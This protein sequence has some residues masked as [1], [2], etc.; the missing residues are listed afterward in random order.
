V[1]TTCVRFCANDG[2]HDVIRFARPVGDLSNSLRCRAARSTFGDLMSAS[3]G[4]GS[5]AVGFGPF[6]LF[7]AERLLERDGVPV[8]LG[9]RAIDILI[10]LVCRAGEVVSR[11][12]LLTTVWP[13]TV[14]VESC[15]RVQVASLRKALGDGV[16]GARFVT[17]VAGRGYCFVAPVAQQAGARS[18]ASLPPVPKEPVAWQLAH[19]LP[20]RLKRMAGRDD[21][22]DIVIAQLREHRFVTIVGAGGIGKTTVAVSVGHALLSD[23]S[24]AVRFVDLQS[25]ADPDLVAPTVASA[26]GLIVQTDVAVASLEA[27]LRDRRVL[28]VLDNC[29]HIVHAAAP[30]TERL[31]SQAPG[32]H[33]LTT[34]REALRVEGERVHRL[35]P[36]DAPTSY[37][38]LNASAV[39]AFP[40]VQVFMERA[41]ASGGS[42]ELTDDDAP[43][44]AA[45]CKR[46][47]GVALAIEVAAGFVGQFGVRGTAGLLDNRFRLLRQQGRR[48]APPRQRTLNALIDW[49]YDRLPEYERLVLRRLSVFF[50]PFT[51]EAARDVATDSESET[52]QF[53]DAVAELVAKSLVSGIADGSTILYRLLETTRAYATERIVESGERDGIAK[54]HALY[55]AALLEGC[56]PTLQERSITERASYLSNIRAG[57]Q[58]SF[59]SQA[60]LMTGVRLAAA[61]APLLLDLT[62]LSEC[63]YSTE[64][65]L[66]V[67]DASSR[68]DSR[69]MVLQ[70][71]FAISTM[72][73]RGNSDNVRA[74]IMRGL[75]L[76]DALGE[77]SHELRLLA[78]LNIF[79]TRIGDFLGALGAAERAL[80]VAQQ[81]AKPLGM[82]MAEW[83]L[84]V[85]HH[86]AGNQGLAL[87][88]C[89]RGM[90][91]AGASGPVKTGFFGY[92]HRVRALVAL[93]R[94]L[95]LRG[96]SEQAVV[97]ARRAI[98]AAAQ[99]DQPID[100]CISFI[101]TA[102]VFLWR[103]DWADARDVIERLIAHAERHSLAPYHAVGQALKGE[104]CVK[105]GDAKSGC[106]MLLDAS[107]RLRAE[108]HTILSTVIAAALA[109][110]R[111][112]TGQVDGALATIEEAIAEG[113]RRGEPFDM[114]ELLR[115]KGYLLA[116]SSRRDQR[117]AEVYLSRSLACARRQGALAWEL[118]TATTRAGFGLEMPEARNELAA[119]YARFTEGLETIDLRAARKL[120]EQKVSRASAGARECRPVT[121]RARTKSC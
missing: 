105:L 4:I 7:P 113:E 107:H 95:W 26:L 61:A 73:T 47:D 34:S 88:H 104:L 33:F 81:L 28:L 85:A 78:G 58:W 56:D 120:L 25:L 70:E 97:V 83:M 90:K 118:R 82:A 117:G 59:S 27:F 24:G 36:L 14:V 39:R 3:N 106:Q 115:V 77:K 121:R 67:M 84:G 18:H 92:D 111:A 29:E 19:G 86:L 87:Q 16:D 98:E 103:G 13:D 37:A 30:L 68:G 2:R 42:S 116:L 60:G 79:L 62:L 63:Q 45:I 94:V 35:G 12:D 72:F 22:I 23:F 17:N 89:E 44:V 48:T 80:A 43:I 8:E 74:A 9:G 76:A 99:L 55:F 50:G 6:R 91:Y 109:E 114:P 40:A 119:V 101:Y 112:M 53:T 65:A 5:C 11:T 110:G 10:A 15:L 93:C 96:L 32:V 38:G 1:R 57:L 75:E 46:L 108:R 102:S 69:E 51:M 49:S 21:T 20:P 64:R 41:A 71:A 54:R 66:A 52:A 100:V 31:F